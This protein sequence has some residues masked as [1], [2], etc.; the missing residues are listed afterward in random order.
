M[1]HTSTPNSLFI[2]I[3]KGLLLTA[4]L[5]VLP[6]TVNAQSYKVY[7][8]PGHGSWGPNDRP[9]ATIPYPMLE[10]TGRPDTCGFYESNTNLWKAFE[11]GD[12]LKATGKFK[13]KY[14]RRKN[15]PYPYVSGASNEDKYN[16]PLSVIAAEVDTWGADLFLSIHS[17]ASSDGSTANYP[18]FLYRGTDAENSVKTSRDM[19]ETIWPYL[20]EIMS[21]GFE[22]SS[23]YKSSKNIR[24]DVDFYHSSWTN[25]KGYVGYLGV[26]M[27]GCPGFLSEGYFHT[28]QPSRHRALNEDWCR[29][30]GYR[31]ARG[32]KEYFGVDRDT[33][34]CIMGEV[35]TKATSTSTLNYYNYASGTNDAYLPLN[36]TTVRLT[37]RMR[38]I[39]STYQVDQNYNGIY[40][41]NDLEP[42]V[43]Y[44]D[45]YCEGY[46]TQ[47]SRKNGITVRAN[48]TAYQSIFMTPSKTS[49]PL[50]EPSTAIEEVEDTPVYADRHSVRLYDTSGKLL[51][52]TTRQSLDNVSLPDG[53]YLTESGGRTVKWYHKK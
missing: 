3:I 35:R 27:H 51:L 20:H 22:Y 17:N 15:G 43:Y 16:R 29:A 53:I 18:L 48:T 33:L 34:G 41:F 7:L 38:N 13:M 39:I 45:V 5:F 28:Y 24:G 10:S 21:A 42:G 23:H 9:L 32:I 49:I 4:T 14:S 31:Y 1:K 2:Y 36:G 8:N 40:V 25:N 52:Q 26:L 50:R 47:Q 19:A 46:A 37:D 30:E 44:V 11:C 12:R 6:L